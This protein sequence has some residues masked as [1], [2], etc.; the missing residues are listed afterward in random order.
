MPMPVARCRAA[1]APLVACLVLG[2]LAGCG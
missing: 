2:A 1:A